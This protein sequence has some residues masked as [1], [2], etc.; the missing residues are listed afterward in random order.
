MSFRKN[1]STN[2]LFAFALASLLA[3]GLAGCGGGGG[4]GGGPTMGTPPATM[5]SQP[6]A[7]EIER[8]TV[9]IMP[10]PVLPVSASSSW[11]DVSIPTRQGVRQRVLL[12]KA[13]NAGTKAVILFAGGNGTPI[14]IPRG[15]GIR[16][17]G[18]FL[19]RSS[20]FF[21]NDGFITAIVDAPSDKPEGPLGGRDGGM[22][23]DFRQ[24]SMHLTD[25]RAVVD[26]LVSEGAREVFLIATSRGALSVAYLATVIKN[27][28]VKGYVL[29]ASVS[30]MA[31]YAPRITDPVLMV[32]HVDDVRCSTTRYGD[33]QV[34]YDNIPASTRKHFITISGGDPPIDTNPCQARTAHGFLGKEREVV[35]GIV[36]WMN[37]ETP[38]E[39]VS[40]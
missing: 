26:F 19:V 38:L 8:E 3:L 21:A 22:T 24:S 29:T 27:A 6:Q 16:F 37:G 7:R 9:D 15:Q 12:T 4:G 39:C 31:P 2:K 11:E 33:A 28:N 32:H 10:H 1:T 40:P 17:S 25:I 35:G 36:K 18:N 34:I 30:D 20:A 13:S 5:P 23:D 14:T